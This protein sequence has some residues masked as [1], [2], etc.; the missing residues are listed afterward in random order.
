MAPVALP[1]PW[2]SSFVARP[3]LGD[4][5]VEAGRLAFEAFARNR[6]IL[7]SDAAALA[8]KRAVDE[9]MVA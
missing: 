1:T 6:G 2:H 5:N 3:L 8:T 4:V 7:A 9:G